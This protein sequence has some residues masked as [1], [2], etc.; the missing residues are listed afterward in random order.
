VVALASLLSGQPV[1][2]FLAMTGEITLRGQ[3]LPIGGLKE[4]LLAAYRAGIRTVILP[5]DNRKDTRE[6]PPEIRKG[7]KLKFFSQT[8][9]AVKYA[10]EGAPRK[11]SERP[12]RKKKRTA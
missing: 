6:L 5:Q 11:E 2:P 8:L 4:K 10:L 7:L 12:R 9:A 1:K 3:I